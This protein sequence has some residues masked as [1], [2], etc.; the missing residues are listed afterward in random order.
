MI[1]KQIPPNHLDDDYLKKAM[2]GT[3][4]TIINKTSK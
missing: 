1:N 2:E 3:K 4:N